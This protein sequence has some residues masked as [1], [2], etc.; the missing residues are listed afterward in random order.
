MTILD[1]TY[2]DKLYSFIDSRTSIDA[3]TKCWNWTGTINSSGYAV[4][5][6]SRKVYGSKRR[7]PDMRVHRINYARFKG[8][9][10]NDLHLL[11]SCDNRKCINPNHVRTGDDR[12]NIQDAA[13][14]G[15]MYK[16]LG[17]ESL[18]GI[19]RRIESGDSLS[20]IARAYDLDYS[21]V[22]NI[23][24]GK[25]HKLRLEVLTGGK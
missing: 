18:L 25:Q 22:R 7:G 1:K 24:L 8:P 2:L 14:K 23:K 5:T 6:G 13:R 21:M 15:R 19:V 12:D 3:L 9:L 4:V 11:H 10:P 20:E 16:K 17:D